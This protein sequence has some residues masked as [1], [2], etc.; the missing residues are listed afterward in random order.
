MIL[1]TL[2]AGPILDYL[3]HMADVDKIC[4]S[5]SGCIAGQAVA[6]AV[7]DVLFGQHGGVYNDIDVFTPNCS[8]SVEQKILRTVSM[9]SVESVAEYGQLTAAINTRYKV[10]RTFRD[11]LLNVV[12]IRGHYGHR[13]KGGSLLL[14][15]DVIHSFDLNCVQVAI[16]LESRTL[17]WTPAFEKFLATR[18]IE[19]EN[20]HTPAHTA[21]RLVKKLHELPNVYADLDRLMKV[22]AGAQ[23]LQQV[24]EGRGAG[25]A[26][27]SRW[28]ELA[29]SGMYRAPAMWGLF[30]QRLFGRAYAEKA[31][32]FEK[33]LS[34][35]FSLCHAG[36]SEHVFTLEPQC[37][38]DEPLLQYGLMRHPVQYPILA[39]A[40]M[41]PCKPE[42]RKRWLAL[43]GVNKAHTGV[44]YW[45][46]SR[47]Q[48]LE[49]M[50]AERVPV[51]EVNEVSG[52]VAKHPGLLQFMR[53]SES[54]SE[55][56]AILQLFKREAA[57]RGEWVWGFAESM[58]AEGGVSFAS[59]KKELP[60]MLEAERKDMLV[61]LS[62]EHLP[63]LARQIRG[64]RIRELRTRA[65]LFE[66][67]SDMHHCV[68][69]Y[70]RAVLRGQTLIL[71]LRED[72]KDV[73][74]WSTAELFHYPHSQDLPLNQTVG[75]V[76]HRGRFNG[77]PPEVNKEA[78]EQV[79]E[80]LLNEKAFN[81]YPLLAKAGISPAFIRKQDD[82]I[83]KLKAEARALC[84]RVK[85]RLQGKKT[86][87]FAGE[88]DQIPF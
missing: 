76:Q 88:L 5:R 25:E 56:C 26:G 7:Q 20:T 66:E 3:G 35:W 59:L 51:K 11:E 4:R 19:I 14:T 77:N 47:K 28:Q 80:I 34:P 9:V 40:F 79:I 71:S 43:L 72:R 41:K 15:H 18:Q 75:I 45:P 6:S 1:N 83:F 23:I 55:Q 17:I 85:A 87:Y 33:S 44:R 46:V 62:G 78:L 10:H 74:S 48:S 30:C 57:N 81:R 29:N 64:V 37:A 58:R 42:Q 38:P 22:L 32:S 73:S 24:R 86:R 39:N 27:K 65:A 16:D 2:D 52:L 21:I 69:G 49:S 50:A 70:A 53:T 84:F 67:G 60:A 82:N 68:G 31:R 36:Q 8:E 12:E 63:V 13:Q 61:E 54:L